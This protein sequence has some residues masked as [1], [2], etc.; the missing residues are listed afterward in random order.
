M[1]GS[2]AAALGAPAMLFASPAASQEISMIQGNIAG[3]VPAADADQ[4]RMCKVAPQS[5][6]QLA[7]KPYGSPVFGSD[8]LTCVSVEPTAQ[9]QGP[10]APPRTDREPSSLAF[11]KF[12][13]QKP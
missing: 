7:Y 10:S 8:G 9:A 2:V 4:P 1:K 5:S 6:I 3:P 11:L 13:E 12:V